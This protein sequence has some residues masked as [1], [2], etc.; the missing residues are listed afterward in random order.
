MGT[1]QLCS[2]ALAPA[3]PAA[4][5]PPTAASRLVQRFLQIGL[6]IAAA[7][8][9]GSMM[10]TS[11]ASAETLPAVGS[12]ARPPSL[13]LDLGSALQGTHDANLGH[14]RVATLL[15]PTLARVGG[16]AGGVLGDA[17]PVTQLQPTL[18]S[19]SVSVSVSVSTRLVQPVAGLPIVG[20]ARVPAATL[21][22]DGLVAPA[23]QPSPRRIGRAKVSRVVEP[24]GK[25]AAGT[26][27]PATVRA[28]AAAPIANSAVSIR[29][30]RTGSHPVPPA[31]MAPR[32]RAPMPFAPAPPDPA[33]TA[34]PAGTSA[35]APSVLDGGPALPGPEQCPVTGT[36]RAHDPGGLF[37]SPP[38]SPD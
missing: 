18:P 6:M 27:V 23:D 12:Q 25:S 1:E 28:D 19:V 38:F 34:S 11:Q 8:L 29:G 32:P 10:H 31:P 35:A 36:P 14:P 37:S 17:Q 2:T 13:V 21:A 4:G 20:A 9:L 30:V 26:G 22:A 24:A 5:S 33:G 7:W 16:A 3:C 15:E